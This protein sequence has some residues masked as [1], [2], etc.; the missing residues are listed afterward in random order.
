MLLLERGEEEK[1]GETGGSEEV[2]EAEESG[3]ENTCTLEKGG[4]E[5]DSFIVAYSAYSLIYM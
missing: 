3:A 1:T 2:E 5:S 4:F